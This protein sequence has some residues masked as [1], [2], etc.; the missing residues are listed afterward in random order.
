M[1]AKLLAAILVLPLFGCAT[2]NFASSP[3]PARVQEEWFRKEMTFW[4]G[5]RIFAI[6]DLEFGMLRYEADTTFT[7]NPGSSVVKVWYYAN[8]G[9]AKGL[10]WQTDVVSM[11]A[12][13]KPNGRYQVRS[14]YGDE[15][16]SFSLVD[17]DANV[18]IAETQ[19]VRIV[20]RPSPSQQSPTF[21]PIFIPKR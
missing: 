9:D 8:R 1:F 16:V 3:T 11:A 21:I 10:F 20:R 18:R 6:G 13:L 19:P 5:T 14:N 4:G 17:L 15:E 7:V 12:D 2:T